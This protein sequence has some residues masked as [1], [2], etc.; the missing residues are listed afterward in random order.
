MKIEGAAKGDV[1]SFNMY[2][3]AAF[4]GVDVVAK[5]RRDGGRDDAPHCQGGWRSV[6]SWMAKNSS[7]S[8]GKGL[9]IPATTRHTFPTWH[10]K[11]LDSP[12]RR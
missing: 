11:P 2:T 8:L 6:K 4:G 7:W 9:K 5:Q 3:S 1:Y 10:C 12:H